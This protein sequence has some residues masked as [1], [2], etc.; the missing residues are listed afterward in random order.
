MELHVILENHYLKLKAFIYKFLPKLKPYLVGMLYRPCDK[1][2]FI[3]HLDN[4]FKEINVSN[5]KNVTS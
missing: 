3:E 2:E 1:L 5:I 4:S